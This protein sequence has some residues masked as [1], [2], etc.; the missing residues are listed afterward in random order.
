MKTLKLGIIGYNEG[1]GH[2]YSFSAIINGFNSDFINNCPYPVIVNYLKQRSPF[3][4]G[5]HNLKIDYIWTPKKKIS[6]DIAKCCNI[7]T[8]VEHYSV[9]VNDVDAVI[10]ARD[11]AESHKEI[12][13][14]FLNEGKFVF[15]DKPLCTNLDDL[16]YFLPY[17]RDGLIMSSSG[18][19]YHPL[20]L[21]NEFLAKNRN[22]IISGFAITSVDWFKYGI[23]VLE[24]FQPLMNSKII[25]VQN[26]GTTDNDLVHFQYS[27][28]KEAIILK[29]NNIK[30]FITNFYVS[31]GN[32]IEIKYNDNFLYF[33]N[34]LFAFH[35]FI[36]QKKYI[37]NYQETENL[38]KA[39]IAASNSKL[40][41]CKKITIY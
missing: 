7:P 27:N 17:L 6:E 38:I 14:L 2:P 20:F 36:T 5:I 28:G 41:G 10:I 40:N 19:R 22:K 12:A 37:F 18:F 23:H 11:D 16:N 29:N 33:R 9:F 30:D 15:I 8:V 35:D 34:M 26:I 13:S 31:D 24:A 21:N 3:E 39:L 4:F 1:N 32:H 25:S